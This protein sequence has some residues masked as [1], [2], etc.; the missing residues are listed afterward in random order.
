M[1]LFSLLFCC[2]FSLAHQLE[3][4]TIMSR[5]SDNHGKG[6]Y[7]VEQSIEWSVDGSPMEILETW[8]VLGESKMHL[9][10][11]GEG[12]LNKL[13]QGEVLYSSQKKMT[14][15]ASGQTASY[16]LPRS[17][18]PVFF[19]YRA[20]AWMR[21]RMVSLKMAPP[22]SLQNRPPLKLVDKPPYKAQDFISLQRVGGALA[23]GIGFPGDPLLFIEQDQFVVLK[24]K[25]DETRSVVAENYKKFAANFYYPELITYTFGPNTVKARLKKVTYLGRSPKNEIF[26]LSSERSNLAL[27]NEP[28]I[29]E[30]YSTF[31]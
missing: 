12:R 3:Y 16:S 14:K 17:F 19:H 27:P 26:Q 11:Q 8:I 23:Y 21:E 13:V 24:I 2:L 7:Q 15:N 25:F 18:S 9:K 31:R 5:T 1:N 6:A 4:D 30:F 10:V 28:I 22:Q 29:R 20:S